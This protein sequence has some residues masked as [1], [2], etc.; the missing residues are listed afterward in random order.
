MAS[1]ET[2]DAFQ[3]RLN[4]AWNET[5]LVFENDGY[6]LP[7]MPAPFLYVEIYGDAYDQESFGAPEQNMFLE[8]GATYL[9]MM[10]PSF[11]GSRQARVYVN[12]ALNL[13]REQPI[14]D[15]FMPKMS[16]GA[17]E[18]GRDFP[19]YWALTGTIEWYRRDITNL[20]TP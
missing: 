1:P 2:F 20:P 7:D 16:I 8:E 6:Q 17:G 15:L 3:A 18:P 11:T 19:N 10:V 12:A 14:G 5:P 13:F 4:S 9:H